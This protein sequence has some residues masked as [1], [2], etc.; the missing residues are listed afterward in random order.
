MITDRANGSKYT[1]VRLQ[2]KI[3]KVVRPVMSLFFG[4]FMCVTEYIIYE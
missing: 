4:F 3:E 2:Y 1:E